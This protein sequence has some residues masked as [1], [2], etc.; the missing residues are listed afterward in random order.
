[1]IAQL[2]G[3]IVQVITARGGVSAHLRVMLLTNF[4]TMVLSLLTGSLQ[5]QLLGPGGRGELA[6]IQ[7][8]GFFIIF[9]GHIDVPNA[10]IY[11]VSQ[12]NERVGSWITSAWL[13]MLP[14]GVGWVLLG[15][16]VLPLLMQGINPDIIHAAQVFML[17]VPIGYINLVNMALLGMKKFGHWS[18]YRI[19]TP[20]LFVILLLY[21]GITGSATPFNIAYGYLFILSITALLIVVLLQLAHI[22]LE[23]PT[24]QRA[25][26]LLSYG[27]RSILGTAP[28]MMNTR[29]DQLILAL[30]VDSR[31]VG[32]YVVSVSWSL[33]MTEGLFKALGTV[34]FPHLAGELDQERR[35]RLTLRA[36]NLSARAAVLLAIGMAVATPIVFPLLFGQEFAA[37][38]PVAL[39]LVGASVFHELKVVMSDSLRGLGRPGRVAIAECAALIVTCV[40]LLATVRTLGIMGA[41]L[42][43]MAAYALAA[44]FMAFFLRNSLRAPQNTTPGS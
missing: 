9:M 8:W 11:Y 43:S 12:D 4:A 28:D 29:V 15:L 10:L 16:L 30:L 33:T 27:A 25:R 13:I 21:L 19:H 34:L 20:L 35:T 36:V 38:I 23:R 22:R 6:Q 44:S 1:M 5:A 26:Q 17:A 14:L 39:I 2:S 40:G 37:A 32:L 24:L 3:K 31:F 41:A 7:L 42:T 18:V